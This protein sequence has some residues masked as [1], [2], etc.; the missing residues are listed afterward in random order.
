MNDTADS[1]E[2]Q[3]QAML[4]VLWKNN[5]ATIDERVQRLREA[6]TQLSSDRMDATARKEAESAAHKLAGV[7]GTF[8]LPE[9]SRIASSIELLFAGDAPLNDHAK[10]NLAKHLNELEAIIASKQL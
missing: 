5:R 10:S 3:L 6:Q 9:G 1:P 2:N 4:R 8:G 7:L